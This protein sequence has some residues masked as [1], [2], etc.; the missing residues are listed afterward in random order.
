MMDRA[1][2]NRIKAEIAAAGFGAML[3][4]HGFQLVKR[5][6]SHWRLDGDRIT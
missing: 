5:S 6:K 4:R 3:E 1:E 2:K